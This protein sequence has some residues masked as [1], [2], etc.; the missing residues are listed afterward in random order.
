MSLILRLSAPSALLLM[1]AGCVSIGPQE[2]DLTALRQVLQRLNERPRVLVDLPDTWLNE[3][4]A[5]DLRCRSN[6]LSRTFNR[7]YSQNHRARTNWH[8]FTEFEVHCSEED[9]FVWF[10]NF[11]IEDQRRSGEIEF[12]FDQLGGACISPIVQQRTEGVIPSSSYYSQARIQ[13]GRLFVSFF[14][15]HRWK[16][17]AA[18]QA[19]ID[20]VT[21]RLLKVL[22]DNTSDLTQ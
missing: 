4:G 8:V 9:A 17:G 3:A 20:D 6:S 1:A 7:T 5:A 15:I 22:E 19:A 2:I 14:E 10:E 21:V 16:L 18:K 12:I 13:S 11:C